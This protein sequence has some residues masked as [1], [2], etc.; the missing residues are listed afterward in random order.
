[1]TPGFEADCAPLLASVRRSSF[2]PAL[3]ALDPEARLDLTV[4]YAFCR[5]VDDS[6]DDFAPA[7][8]KLHTATWARALKSSRALRA[9]HAPLLLA[10]DELCQRRGIPLSLLRQLARGAQS[11]ARASVRVGTR[12]DLE[13][14]CQ[15]VAGCVGEA[16]L[17]IFGVDI[18]AGAAF[19]RSLGRALQLINI[20]RDAAEDVQRGRVYLAQSD[21]RRHGLRDADL[22]LATQA[23]VSPLLREY[24]AW[25]RASLDQAARATRSLPL[26]KLKAPLLM[27]ELYVALLDQMEKDGLRVF[28]RRYRVPVWRRVWIVVRVVFGWAR[29]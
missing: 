2:G 27:R 23:K 14:Y 1:M 18:K 13:D 7:Q 6:A 20:L 26:K 28:S 24:A 5:A 21:M 29:W 16:C 25:A 22:S 9:T 4:F 11:D 15:K 17:P 12:R 19:A 3:W 8:A 10:L